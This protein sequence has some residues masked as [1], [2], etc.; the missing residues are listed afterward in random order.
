V[1]FC[2]KHMP[3]CVCHWTLT[4]AFVGHRHVPSAANQHTSWRSVIRCCFTS[5][6]EQS[7]N[8]AARVGHYTRTVSTNIQNASIWSL[9]T[10]ALSD[11]VFRVLCTN[12][13]LTYL[14]TGFLWSG[15]VMEFWGSQG[16]SGKTER[17]REK[18]GNFK[19]LLTRPI[20]YA[21]FSQFLSAS[22][23]FAPRPRPETPPGLC[24]CKHCRL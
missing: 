7:A 24:P 1:V 18:S 4:A 23:G 13:L 19:I 20:I 5:L 10:A 16:K 15:K 12:P 17:V 9:I 22:G 2:Y 8:P 6:M 14:C 3:T 11:N 21:L